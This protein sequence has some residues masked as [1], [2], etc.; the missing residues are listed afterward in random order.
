MTVR[1]VEGRE[2]GRIAQLPAETHRFHPLDDAP[3]CRA[4]LAMSLDLDQARFDAEQTDDLSRFILDGADILP[5]L[6]PTRQLDVDAQMPAPTPGF[7]NDGRVIA[8]ED[9]IGQVF[10]VKRR[11]GVRL[12]LGDDHHLIGIHGAHQQDIRPAQ[13]GRDRHPSGDRF[14]Q[15]RRWSCSLIA[16]GASSPSH[17]SL[18][19]TLSKKE[20]WDIFPP[21]PALIGRGERI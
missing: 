8:G 13:V 20:G 10:A 1:L 6:R 9:A 14:H 15:S 3:E 18:A 16:H 2:V 19:A 7:Q 17:G 5:H 12:G 11:Y 4:A 21:P